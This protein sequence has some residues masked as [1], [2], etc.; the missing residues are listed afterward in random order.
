MEDFWYIKYHVK[1]S[2]SAHFIWRD[3]SQ[4]FYAHVLRQCMYFVPFRKISHT[5][6]HASHFNKSF[7]YRER[8][9]TLEHSTSECEL[10]LHHEFFKWN[11]ACSMVSE[12]LYSHPCNEDSSL[13]QNSSE[14]DIRYHVRVN[15]CA[16][17]STGH[18]EARDSSAVPYSRQDRQPN[19][20]TCSHPVNEFYSI[21]IVLRFIIWFPLDSADFIHFSVSEPLKT[22]GICH[23]IRMQKTGF[24]SWC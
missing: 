4:I 10:W 9:R 24:R 11:L 12:T 6:E 13:P 16:R 3:D 19:C 17:L 5:P 20:F 7:F 15:V 22:C 21:G 23:T 1:Y 8:V 14:D 18:R 2:T